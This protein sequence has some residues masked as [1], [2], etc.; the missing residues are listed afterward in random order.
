MD[1]PLS[2]VGLLRIKRDQGQTGQRDNK[3]PADTHTAGPCEKG[4]LCVRF[5]NKDGIEALII[6]RKTHVAAAKDHML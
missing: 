4:N 6:S 3:K 5:Q 1:V 2:N